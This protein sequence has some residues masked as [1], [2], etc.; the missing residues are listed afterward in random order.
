MKQLIL[1]SYRVL[2]LAAMLCPL[3]VASPS[4][5]HAAGPGDPIFG[6][7]NYDGHPDRV[8]LGQFVD[9]QCEV[10]VEYG[11]SFQYR[12]P[13]LHRYQLPAGASAEVC[14]DLGVILDLGYDGVRELVVG[15]NFGPHSYDLIVLRDFQPVR[16]FA[17]SLAQPSYLGLS[18]FNGDGL[19]DIYVWGP[20]HV[21]FIT[22]L[23]THR[24]E[25]V[26]GP[27][28]GW[29][30]MEVRRYWLPDLDGDGAT[31]LVLLHDQAVSTVLDDGRRSV[32]L[33]LT[34][35][36][37]IT[38]VE[39]LDANEDRRPDIRVLGAYDGG[40]EQ[41]WLFLTRPNGRS[42][43]APL[44]VNDIVTVQ[45]DRWSPLRVRSNDVAS[46]DAVLTIVT[47]PRYGQVAVTSAGDLVYRRT[48]PHDRHDVV[49]YRLTDRGRSDDGTVT[50]RLAGVSDY[51]Q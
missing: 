37:R 30:E 26:R 15:F 29:G 14:P 31:D 33:D 23:N 12:P 48:A 16:T 41:E 4:A 50:I 11:T 38:D 25:L 6:D 32:L 1:A 18:D 9:G 20:Q 19:T 45:R 22:L 42:V 7:L 17:N 39:I 10:R 21:S 46:V 24:G 51:G 8:T 13:V 34:G 3:V 35:D 40:P 43:L 28:V 2:F 44:A 36:G 47:P 5:A 27:L 49:V